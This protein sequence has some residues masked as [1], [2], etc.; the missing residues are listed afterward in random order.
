MALA[1]FNDPVFKELSLERN[2]SNSTTTTRTKKKKKIIA[3]LPAF[4]LND[5]RHPTPG[6]TTVTLSWP[7]GSLKATWPG[8]ASIS[9]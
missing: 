6:L 8:L 1:L 9:E 5:E 2:I 3:C 4:L 7:F